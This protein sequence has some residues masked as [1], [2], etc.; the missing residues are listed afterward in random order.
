MA[1]KLAVG[2]AKGTNADNL[3][4]VMGAEWTGLPDSNDRHATL[5]PY[6]QAPHHP[7]P[8]PRPHPDSQHG[9]GTEEGHQPRTR[10]RERE[11]D[12]AD[13]SRG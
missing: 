8:A 3:S 5:W 10:E 7:A 13:A 11:R 9:R 1:D 2:V 4:T 6:Y 12:Y